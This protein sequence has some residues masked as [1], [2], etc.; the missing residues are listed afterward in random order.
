[1]TPTRLFTVAPDKIVEY[2]NEW[3][4]YASNLRQEDL[5]DWECYAY[6]FQTDSIIGPFDPVIETDNIGAFIKPPKSKYPFYHND[7]ESP[8]YRQGWWQSGHTLR[9]IK[10]RQTEQG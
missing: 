4:R 8:G 3:P 5:A 9:F 1:M 7:G 6:D 10:K 2:P